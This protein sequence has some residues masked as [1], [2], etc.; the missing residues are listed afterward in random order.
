MGLKWIRKY[1]LT[2]GKPNESGAKTTTQSVVIMDSHIEFDVSI[3][4]K[5]DLNTLELKIYN[6]SQSTIAVFDIEN[7]QVTLEV[8]YG[9][10][11]L[12]V[13]FKGEKFAMNTSRKGTEIITLVKAA[14]GSVATKEGVANV[15]LPE[16][17][18]VKDI[19]TKLKESMPDIK[20][21]NMNGEGLDK[22]YNGG[23]SASGNIKKA[24][25]DICSS[26]NLQWHIDKGDTINVY[27]LNGDTKVKAFQ[28]N[29]HNGLIN[30]VERSNKELNKLKKDLEL[31]DDSGIKLECLLNPLVQAGGVIQLQGTFNS[32]GNYRVDKVSHSGGY[33]SEEWTTT[34][35]ATKY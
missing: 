32:D 12:V 16:G 25:D 26:N 21:L 19:I 23:F 31:E 22:A 4:G 2:I 8:G 7:V 18:K 3:T 20:T 14:E 6:L 11:P 1:K 27:P 10:E 15:T 13:L 9:D 34:I 5:S 30:T 29:P 17:V 28:I 24:M 33:E 35:E